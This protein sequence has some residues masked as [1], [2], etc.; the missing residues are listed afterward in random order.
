MKWISIESLEHSHKMEIMKIKSMKWI[1]I[2]GRRSGL[3]NSQG[4]L[5][6]WSEQWRHW[7]PWR[8]AKREFWA[9]KNWGPGFLHSY[10]SHFFARKILHKKTWKGTEVGRRRPHPEIGLR[11]PF[12][13]QH[14]SIN[15]WLSDFPPCLFVSFLF[16]EKLPPILQKKNERG[17]A[18]SGST[19]AATSVQS[20]GHG[21]VSIGC[22][23]VTLW[24][25]GTEFL[26]VVNQL[27]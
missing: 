22:D 26:R 21:S 13:N 15:N 24:G 8:V 3:L 5:E 2:L 12:L 14:K 4:H 9:K 23:G 10:S 7:L 11:V 19:F 16:L 20:S 6:K 1:F 17:A 27:L 25:L 18:P